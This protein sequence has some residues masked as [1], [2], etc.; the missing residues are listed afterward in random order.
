MASLIILALFAIALFVHSHLFVTPTIPSLYLSVVGCALWGLFA[1]LKRF[2]REEVGIS[3]SELLLTGLSLFM[4]ITGICYQSI[5]FKF[6]ALGVSLLLFY[7]LVRRTTWNWKILSAG[8]LILGAVEAV[9][10]IGQHFHWF[11]NARVDLPI[12]GSFDNPAGLSATLA[13]ISPFGLVLLG[14]KSRIWKISGI[15]SLSVIYTAIVLSQSRAG[16][17]AAFTVALVFCIYSL[18][19][20]QLKNGHKWIKI[21]VTTVACT[22]LMGGLYFVK[23]DSADGRLL[24]WQCTSRMIADKPFFGQGTGGFQREYMLYQADYFVHHPEDSKFA[25]LADIVKHP[26]NEYLLFLSE[27]GLL[28]VA[29]FGSFALL[30]IR[31]YRNERTEE[32]LCLIFCLIGIGVFACFSYPFDYAFPRLITVFAAASIMKGESAMFHVSRKVWAVSKPVIIIFLL[33]LIMIPCKMLCDEYQWNMIAQ[34]SLR[35]ETRKVLPDYAKLHKTMNRNGLFLYNYAAELNYIGE[36]RK[37]NALIQACTRFYND[38]DVQLIMADNY[39]NLKQHKEAE[40]HLKLA[41]QMIPNRFIPLYRLALLYKAE[42]RIKDAKKIAGQILNK[43]V[44]VPSSEVTLIKREMK[45]LKEQG[46]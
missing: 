14:E 38:I 17:V 25:I 43:P 27:Q 15:L 33:L 6:A 44:K 12:C 28:G 19:R 34:R 32:N 35:G 11:A 40:K 41:S 42:D 46:E 31:S 18:P 21:T 8:F 10:A 36:W 39:M 4:L 24:I 13:A 23:K 29:L 1:L 45:M 26:F 5:N 9:Y 37:S 22:A 16:M 7:L 2:R 30:L 3:L 20:L